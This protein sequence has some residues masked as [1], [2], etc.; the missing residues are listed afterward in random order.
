ME[1]FQELLETR[2]DQIDEQILDLILSFVDFEEFKALILDAKREKEMEEE[3]KLG[4]M[5]V[6]RGRQQR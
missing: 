5:F 6:I 2:K 1:R 4:D 3:K